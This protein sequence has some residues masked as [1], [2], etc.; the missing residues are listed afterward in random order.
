MILHG[1]CKDVMEDLP[2][3][4]YDSMITDPPAG[5]AFMNKEWDKDKGGRDGW[6]KWMSGVMREAHRVLK[7]GA[8]GF[9]WAL[10]RTSHWTATAL[11]DAGFEIRDIVMHV[12]GSGFPKSLNISKAID[13]A[14]GAEREV[15]GKLPA[16]SG[17]LKNGHVA[18]TGGGM[19][20][21]SE[22]SP[23]INI[24]IPA[25]PEAKQWDGWGT[26]LKPAAEKYIYI[27]K[28][29]VSVDVDTE[30]WLTNDLLK[31]ICL[32]QLNAPYAK[33]IL[34][35]SPNDS[36]TAEKL[37]SVQ[38]LV[39]VSNIQRSL[40]ELE[41]T[42]MFKSQEVGIIILSIVA[43]WSDTLNVV[44]SAVNKF[45]TETV[46]DL[47]TQLRILNSLALKITQGCTTRDEMNQNGL[48]SSVLNVENDLNDLK[49]KLKG[50]LL[51]FVTDNA[52]SVA[53]HIANSCHTL[54]A[55]E[56]DHLEGP[57]SEDI[58]LIRKPLSE[59][60]VAK[61]VL[62][63]GTGGINIDVS[64]VELGDEKQ[65]SGSGKDSPEMRRTM[66]GGK[67]TKKDKNITPPQGRFPANFITSHSEHCTESQ[68]DIECAIKLLDEQSGVSKEPL[69]NERVNKSIWGSSNN[70][71]QG[72]RGH[73]DSGGASR[74]FYCAKSSK[75][76][77]N[78]GCEG[79][80]I[81]KDVEHAHGRY[82]CKT[83]G[84]LKLDHNPCKCGDAANFERIQVNQN[85]HP[86][87]KAQK[88]M[89]YLIQ[90]ITPPGGKVLDPF[91][92]SGS[93]GVAARDLG[94]EFLGIE[95]ESEYFEIAVR[96]TTNKHEEFKES[97]V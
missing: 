15:V 57:L 45:T 59:S 23:E 69:R 96:R 27:R 64:R 40:E 31:E 67:F 22:R 7:P 60:T 21:G 29:F 77:R 79:M 51:L 38:W 44:S 41:K 71:F 8:H 58:I 82:R 84:K 95:K 85:H 65:P 36:K 25:T 35:L 75:A 56:G 13:K 55:I 49:E 34:E 12:F 16:G 47:T 19:S 92:G 94:Y 83:C 24:T 10:P 2:A 6:I 14:A 74:F 91:C 87:V 90:M 1:D 33:Q 52:S 26:A 80:E 11:E 30:L 46:T 88:L 9:V 18:S 28:P 17:P 5:I 32:S 43:L 70:S 78:K 62:A 53:K 73:G 4:E 37:S 48:K 68:C 89:R 50:I 42:D 54:P 97:R 93:T 3:C 39:A 61:N 86:T 72:I 66:S 81:K 20:I 63:Y 76:E